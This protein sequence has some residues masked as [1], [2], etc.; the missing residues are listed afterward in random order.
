[1]TAPAL[2]SPPDVPA[3]LDT[4]WRGPGYGARLREALLPRRLP[5]ACLALMAANLAVFGLEE[6]WGGSTFFVTLKRMGAA[7]GPSSLGAEAWRLLS[8]G[9][10]HL[11]G[12]HLLL[13]MASLVLGGMYLEG[14]LGPSRLLLL[15]TLSILGSN[16]ALAGLYP[17]TLMVG[18]SG[19]IFGLV[20][21]VLVLA[22]HPRTPLPLR[23]RIAPLV[24]ASAIAGFT[25]YSACECGQGSSNTAHLVGAAL[26]MGLAL[27]GVLLWR[28]PW[29]GFRE[30]RSVRVSASA[31]A[32]VTVACLGFGI[33]TERPWEVREAEAQPMVRVELPG[34]AVSLAVP[35]GA[36]ARAEVED[37]SED[38]SFAHV[39]Y[40]DVLTDP[41]A[42]DV[43]VERLEEAV[44]EE[45]MEEETEALSDKLYGEALEPT[46]EGVRME[47]MPRVGTVG[48]RPAVESSRSL[49]ALFWGARWVFYRGRWLITVEVVRLASGLPASWNWRMLEVA[50]SVVVHEEGEPPWDSCTAWNEGRTGMCPRGPW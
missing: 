34:T 49:G 46:E 32:W 26:G 19:G 1:M 13:N 40:G 12:R 45:R 3:P 35:A 21:A 15:Y 50:R 14:M 31:A 28:L 41:L 25:V 37:V 42:M 5:F 47:V 4:P 43:T 2:P 29:P 30:W 33:G 24:C 22:C 23:R 10:L 20:G 11:G 9:Y 38:G 18:A 36:A 16:A 44:P 39:V 8:A 6:L 48:G 17:N 27:T 7:S